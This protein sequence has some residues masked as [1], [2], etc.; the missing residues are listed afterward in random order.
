MCD[1]DID[2]ICVDGALNNC[3]V[4][5]D[6]RVWNQE[7]GAS[8]NLILSQ[9]KIKSAAEV[10]KRAVDYCRGD[11]LFKCILNNRDLINKRCP[12][13]LKEFPIKDEGDA[14]RF[15]NILIKNGFIYRSQYQPLEGIL[16]KDENGMY[17]RPKWPKRLQMTT[18]QQFDIVGFYVIVYEGTQHLNHLLLGL[19][20]L[21][22][23]A[24]CMFPAWPLQMK[25]AL[26]YTSVIF[27]TIMF[28]IIILRLV[29]FIVFWFVVIE[30]WIFPN[31]FNEELGVVD[32][33]KPL[34]SWKKGVYSTTMMACRVF[35]AILLSASIYEL[36]KTHSVSDI[37]RFAKQSFID[38]VDWGYEKL[39]ALPEE[40]THKYIA[41]SKP[42]M[43][44]VD[45]TESDGE[46]KTDGFD[47]YECLKNCGYN[48]LEDLMKKCVRYCSCMKELLDNECIHNC[49][50]EI[51]ALLV[52]AKNES[53]EKEKKREMK[54]R[55]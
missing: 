39:T 5:M 24:G 47:D 51:M 31:M 34:Y 49:N 8:M 29:V 23:L 4:E 41:S 33:F 27:L 19:I 53:C 44:N 50:E 14:I 12:S 42:E 22:V 20:M 18:K 13:Y 26:W 6:K 30:F 43:P 55:H 9:L 17:K 1:I 15:G 32:S 48:G 37:G 11:D 35:C 21:V 16:E 10:G 25:L 46:E 38:V 7:L 28:V 3:L 45:N 52:E 54:K 2:T 40:N 36:G